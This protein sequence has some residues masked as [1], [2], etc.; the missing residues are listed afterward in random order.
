MAKGPLTES[1]KVAMIAS[2]RDTA[3]A[4]VDDLQHIRDIIDRAEP[5]SGDIRRLSNQLRRIIIESDLR[6]V[7]APR[8]GRIE[9]TGPDLRPLYRHVELRPIVF[10][11]GGEVAV[12]GLL[13]DGM[14]LEKGSFAT[15]IQGW[16][17]GSEVSLRLDTFR[18]QRVLYAQGRWVTRGDVIK[19]VA[20]VAHGVHSSDPKDWQHELIRFVRYA[21]TAGKG[22]VPEISL[23]ENA[24]IG[25][26]ELFPPDRTRIDVTL[27]Q[28][29]AAARYLTRSPQV[30][31]LEAIIGEEV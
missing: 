7:A 19:Y 6:E 16:Q 25:P 26:D 21:I 5:S 22:D 12:F 14:R 31:A 10:V 30:Q 2:T 24:I 28:L 23:N 20:N 17:P 9:I 4:L 27:L 13:M 18:D 29:I 15:E 1:D 11:S 3:H 8:V